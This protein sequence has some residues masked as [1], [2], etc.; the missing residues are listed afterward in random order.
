[1][2]AGVVDRGDDGSPFGADMRRVV[3]AG[4]SASADL[5][6]KVIAAVE[7][8]TE[9]VTAATRDAVA[10]ELHERGV[11]IDVREVTQILFALGHAGRIEV[12]DAA[13]G[14]DGLPTQGFYVPHV[15]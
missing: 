13:P 8:V 1:M 11:D 6:A 7:A 5:D 9:N 2:Y 3:A 4:M 14:P 12:V 15:G 10:K